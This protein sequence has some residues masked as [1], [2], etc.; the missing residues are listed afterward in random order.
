MKKATKN[1]TN[2]TIEIF[3]KCQSGKLHW[4]RK[5][6]TLSALFCHLLISASSKYFKSICSNFAL[7]SLHFFHYW[8]WC[9]L[10]IIPNTKFERKN[11]SDC[12]FLDSC[13][14]WF[15]LLFLGREANNIIKIYFEKY[16]MN[17]KKS[18]HLP[19]SG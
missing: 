8:L 11:S 1:K 9:M 4:N 14:C 12:L 6:T 17:G 5:Q 18:F 19:S 13:F 2:N 16:L 10:K 7:E 15:L 3:W